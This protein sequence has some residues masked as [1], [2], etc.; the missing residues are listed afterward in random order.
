[1]ICWTLH[2]ERRVVCMRAYVYGRA[3]VCVVV[4]IMARVRVCGCVDY[5]SLPSTQHQEREVAA[6]EY[7]KTAKKNHAKKHRAQG[8]EAGTKVKFR[9]E[10]SQIHKRTNSNR[11]TILGRGAYHKLE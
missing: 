8:S 9:P 1:M 4:W 5:K 3:F 7:L 2:S 11:A 10:V 6:G